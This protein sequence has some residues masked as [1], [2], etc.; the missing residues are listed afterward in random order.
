MVRT[1]FTINHLDRAAGCIP[2]F[3]PHVSEL[4]SHISWNAG[5]DRTHSKARMSTSIKMSSPSLCSLLRSRNRV[6][7][8]L[9]S[10]KWCL[11]ERRP[12]FFCHSFLS[13]SLRVP[14]GSVLALRTRLPIRILAV[15][16]TPSIVRLTAHL[17]RTP[18]STAFL[19]LLLV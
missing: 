1:K 12:R 7:T 15:N 8:R 2:C 6:P 10:P 5:T 16:S 13:P 11:Y 9:V 3:A 17:A 14:M 19:T 4:L 18:H